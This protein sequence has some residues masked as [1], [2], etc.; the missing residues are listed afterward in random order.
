MIFYFLMKK[1][2]TDT[3]GEEIRRVTECLI[4]HNVKHVVRTVRPRG[5]IGTAMDS[6]SYAISNLAMYKGASTPN[7][8]YMVYVN[9]QDYE[10][11]RDLVYGD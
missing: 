7:Y 9:R 4:K 6:R 5:S 11:A 3:S 10:N 1:L 8:V 2:V